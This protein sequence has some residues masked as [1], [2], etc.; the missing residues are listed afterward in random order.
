M[1]VASAWSLGILEAKEAEPELRAMLDHADAGVR[2]WSAR[3]L[4][5]ITGER[6]FYRNAKGELVLPYNLYR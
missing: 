3:A 1:I 2:E 5:N 4:E 6:V